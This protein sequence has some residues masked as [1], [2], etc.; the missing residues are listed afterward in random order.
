[1]L[2]SVTLNLILLSPKCDLNSSKKVHVGVKKRL[3]VTTT[4]NLTC[5]INI[6]SIFPTAHLDI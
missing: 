6:S 5:E 2:F 1:M 4:G 3:T